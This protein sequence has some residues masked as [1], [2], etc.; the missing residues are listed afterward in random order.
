MQITFVLKERLRVTSLSSLGWTPVK[1][2]RV[3]VWGVFQRHLSVG[4]GSFNLRIR[5]PRALSTLSNDFNKLFLKDIL[6]GQ[7]ITSSISSIPRWSLVMQKESELPELG[8]LPVQAKT[9]ILFQW[10]V[11][12]LPNISWIWKI[13]LCLILILCPMLVQLSLIWWLYRNLHYFLN[14]LLFVDRKPAI[15]STVN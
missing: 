1:P 13:T 7:K 6:C 12:H 4:L 5:V 3:S 11:H 8:D 2:G 9:L 10:L 15:C 14:N